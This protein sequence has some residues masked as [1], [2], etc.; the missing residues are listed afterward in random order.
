MRFEVINDKNKTVMSTVNLS[1]I[2]NKKIL[3]SM[4]MA[5]YKFKLDGKLITAKKLNEIL[6]EIKNDKNNQD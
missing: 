6:K 4:L 3:D 2:P 1:C 5:G